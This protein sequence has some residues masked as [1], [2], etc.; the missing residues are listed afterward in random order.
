MKRIFSPIC[1]AVCL[2]LSVAAH[3]ASV[4]QNLAIQITAT[5]S[6]SPTA[7][8]FSPSGSGNVSDSA[9]P[10]TVIAAGQVATKDG[11][12]FAG[13]VTISAQ[14]AS[15]MVALSSTTLPSNLQVASI[16]SAAHVPQTV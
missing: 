5:Q 11:Q 15:G 10:G 16:S 7:V 6:Q 1:L 12:P 2:G 4:T 9:S 13:T 14:S 3:A 8:S